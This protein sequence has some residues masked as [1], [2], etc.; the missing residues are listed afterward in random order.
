MVR[1]EKGGRLD[2]AE[3]RRVWAE[4][5][6]K[7]ICAIQPQPKL[8]ADDKKSSIEDGRTVAKVMQV[9]LCVLFDG[10]VLID[11]DSATTNSKSQA[12]CGFG[13]PKAGQTASL[14]R[15]CSHPAYITGPRRKHSNCGSMASPRSS[16]PRVSFAH[17]A[18]MP[19]FEEPDRCFEVVANFIRSVSF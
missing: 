12:R 19:F 5:F 8:Y 1:C 6:K 15:R 7:H 14:S 16:E 17:S 10:I 3:Y 9:L 18:H 11:A 4:S 13:Q 2:D